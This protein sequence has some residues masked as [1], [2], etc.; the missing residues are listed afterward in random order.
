MSSSTTPS[1]R[2][3]W[4]SKEITLKDVTKKISNG[5]SIYIGSC[6]ST[7]EATLNAIVNDIGLA[8]IQV[9]Q[10]FPGGN[11]PHLAENIDRFRTSSFFPMTRASFYTPE[12]ATSS[13]KEGLADY[14]PMSFSAIPCLI[15][16]GKLP[17][18]VAIIKCTK[19]HRNF[20]SLGMG[21][22]ITRE[23]IRHAKKFVIAE[24]N[25][26]MPWTEGPSKIHVDQ[27]DFWIQHDAPLLTSAELWS[28]F[29]Q[30]KQHDQQVLDRL[31]KNIIKEIPDGAT[32][33]FGWSPYAWCV[34]P[35][36]RERKDLGL[37]NDLI[38]EDLFRL[39]EDGVINNSK[40][41]I[42]KGRTVVTHAHGTK[43]LYEFLHRNPAIEFHPMAYV[44]DPQV[45]GKID[46]LISIVGALKVDVTGQVATDSIAHKFYGGIWSDD[47]SMQGARFSKG[48]KPIVVLPSRS[49]QGRT[50]IV[51]SLPE[52]TGVSITRSEVEYIITE[53][54]M[55]Y[56]YGKS[57]RERCLELIKIAH[58]D[59][60]EA[61]LDQCKHNHYLSQSQPGFSFKNKYP[62]QFECF[63]TTKKEKEVFIRPIKA[64]DIDMLR[65]FFHTLSDHS[66]YLRYF[67]KVK[68]MPQRILQKTADVDY[69]T[70]MAL[71]VLYPARSP[72]QELI[73]IGQWVSPFNGGIPEIAFQVRDDWQGEGLGTSLFGRLVEIAES[74][75]VVKLKADVLADNHAMRDVIEKSEVQFAAS[76]DFAVIT[77]TFDLSPL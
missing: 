48:G 10:G 61:L 56:V 47:D 64:V 34:I 77:Y 24:V 35:F 45:I 66:V 43:E 25:A 76:A 7:P 39:M 67:R 30:A 26:S 60:R 58:P 53:Y 3:S 23:A 5:N 31:G 4:E 75:D 1:A 9:I 36:L 8:D 37:H 13:A 22:E 2:P 71:V 51:F 59:F 46:N 52:G 74:F 17:I 14:T 73:A 15:Q 69:S 57:I 49:L 42:D 33:K 50:N 20:V 28:Q 55:A 54:G 68:S 44:D 32:L 27:I 72:N 18:D 19:P 41:N 70:D 65:S 6:G 21:V 40:K 12:F 63:H 29:F 11:L 16:E 38:T 62:E